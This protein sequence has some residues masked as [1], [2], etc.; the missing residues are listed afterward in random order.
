[1]PYTATTS[2]GTVL[3]PSGASTCFGLVLFAILH[4]E[5]TVTKDL[6]TYSYNID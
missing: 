2:K 1:M 4:L 5:E 3:L 6:R